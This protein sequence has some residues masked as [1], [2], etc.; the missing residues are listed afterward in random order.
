MIKLL[1][2]L[3]KKE[4]LDASRDK[5]SVMA[6]L[7]Y[8]VGSPILICLLLTVVLNQFS[9]PEG[10]SI[11]I[12]NSQSAPN[13]VEYLKTKDIKQGEGEDVK[14]ITL[15]I[16]NDYL[17]NMSEGRRATITMVADQSDDKLRK[18]IRRVESAIRSYSN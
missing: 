12:E 9:S 13:L 6:G 2:V 8:A 3:Y 1:S 16:S 5:R 18:H 7:Y 14:P 15:I 10:L 17:Q 4:V 11:T